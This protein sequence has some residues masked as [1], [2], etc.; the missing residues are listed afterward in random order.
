MTGV[1]DKF[2]L[3]FSHSWRPHDVD[4]N[5]AVWQLI[6]GEV[7]LLVDAPDEGGADPPYYV[8]RIEELLRRSDLFVCVLTHREEKVEEQASGM[9]LSCSAYSLFEIRLA[10]RFGIPKLVLYERSTGFR[11]PPRAQPIDLYL[12]FDR[13][14]GK[15]PDRRQWR[16]SVEDI[17]EWIG[18]ARR[19]TIPEVVESASLAVGLLPPEA[20]WLGDIE[21]PL[22]RA[23]RNAGYEDVAMR[24]AFRGNVH[25]FQL[26][27]VAGLVV[28]E[29]GD[30][31]RESRELAA[32][33]HALCIPA[34]RLLRDG[35][36]IP[37]LLAGH[38]GG[39]EN[40]LVR[41]K[42]PKDF[43][44]A[45]KSRA[46]AMWQITQA[47]GGEEAHRYLESKRYSSKSVFLS[48]TLKGPEHLLVRHIVGLLG[49][50]FVR[51]FEYQESNETGVEWKPQLEAQLSKATHFVALLSQGY[52]QSEPCTFEL[53]RILDRDDEVTI[54]PFMIGGRD[55]PHPKLKKDHHAMINSGDPLADAE[56]IV[57]KIMSRISAE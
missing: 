21:P 49:Q 10:E 39:Y 33:A 34:I 25:L 52:E 37:A 40:D 51:P 23:L 6:D 24:A 31:S 3:Y 14:S 26:L 20:S 32:I 47:L 48:H 4:L 9:Q 36:D 11:A 29:W 16:R 57:E 50:K 53:E 7:E 42:E 43:E 46:S 12:A 54:L 2:A 56:K 5:V 19:Q 15:L 18:S 41:W 44:E 55:K 13:G 17:G 45:V 38:P 30:A 27:R 28:T 8:N 1:D 35:Y 22:K